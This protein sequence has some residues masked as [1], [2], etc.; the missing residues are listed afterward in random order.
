MRRLNIEKPKFSYIIAIFLTSALPASISMA[1]MVDMDFLEKNQSQGAENIEVITDEETLYKGKAT[2]MDPFE[3]INRG[4]FHVNSVLDALL[5]RPLAY[6]YQDLVPDFTKDRLSSFLS[7]LRAPVIFVNDLLQGEIKQSLATLTRFLINS[8]FGFFGVLDVASYA[9]LEAKNNN[10]EETFR[11]WGIASGPYIVLPL[12]GPSS[13]RNLVGDVAEFFVDPY[14]WYM[15]NHHR[16]KFFG[17]RGGVPIYSRAA[18]VSLIAREKALAITE[19]LD[20]TEDPYAQ[21]RILYM[22]NR[23][24]I[25]AIE[26]SAVP[27]DVIINQ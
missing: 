25:N 5:I 12:F 19:K 8:T 6:A 13:F 2:V 26:E 23:L 15:R 9:G 24:I 21:Y 22:Q 4:I 10:F 20:K 7:N 27:D 16:K 1:Q 14:N 17:Q 11:R 3:P 18:I